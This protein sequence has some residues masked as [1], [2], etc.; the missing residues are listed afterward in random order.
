MRNRLRGAPSQSVLSS[1][2]DRNGVLGVLRA[3]ESQTSAFDWNMMLDA[4]SATLGYEDITRAPWD[5]PAFVLQGLLDMFPMVQTLPGDRLIHVQIPVSEN[6]ASGVTA[7]VVWA[8]HV[9]DL[10]VLVSLHY[11]RRRLSKRY[12]RFGSADI[13]QVFVEE[14]AADEVAS[15]TLLD[16]Q[17]NDLL[18]I[19]PEPDAEQ[20][21]IGSVRRTPLCGIGNVLF[22]DWGGRFLAL[23]KK[24]PAVMED[25]QN[26][27]SAFAIIVARNLVKDETEKDL[28]ADTLARRKAIKH[29][30]D[31]DC[32]LQVSRFL[33]NNIHMKSQ[34][35]DGLVAQYSASP[36][37]GSLPRP[38]ALDAAARA[39]P[40]PPN[41]SVIV[42]DEWDV[43]CSYAR[44]L[45][46]FLIALAHV[47]NLEDCESLKFVDL[48]F[49]EIC[50]LALGQQLDDWNGR[51]ALRIT[52]DIWLQVLAVPLVGYR[53]KLRSL[54]WDRVCLVSD[55]G[56]SAWISTLAQCDP[57]YTR[58]GS[59]MLRQG[60][61]C[62]NGV[63]KTGIWDLA[64]VPRFMTDPERAE[65]CGQVAHLR[66]AEKVNLVNPYCGEGEDAF[67]VSARL[68][69]QEVQPKESLVRAGYKELHKY[70]WWAQLSERCIHGSRAPE[71]IKLA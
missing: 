16:T 47:T 26:I 35:I 22:E 38:A 40:Q 2:P 1:T 42:E 9:L 7:L 58:S 19:T 21:L 44:C 12:E 24:N 67:V 20:E 34:Q 23:R 13:D 4:V 10:T 55:R 41:H 46:I 53:K 27:T 14:V 39:E 56:W 68:R 31:K 36:L 64:S 51:D 32:L 18:K 59:V 69:R 66:C 33:F 63:W 3:C 43:I 60:S 28:D 45:S 25:L 17:K 48:A 37:D 62:R 49:S 65:M 54:P 5:I 8:H 52:D 71:D 57:E 30:V 70:L 61:P 6:L 29:N 11:R 50:N 15:I